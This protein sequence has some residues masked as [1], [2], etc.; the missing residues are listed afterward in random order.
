MQQAM[1]DQGCTVT[2]LTGNELAKAHTRFLAGGRS[3]VANEVLYRCVTR[4]Q[5]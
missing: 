4:T 1:R 2:D 5:P 3:A